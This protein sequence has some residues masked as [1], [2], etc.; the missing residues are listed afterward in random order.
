M[1]SPIANY[2]ETVEIGEIEVADI[3]H[4]F[5]DKDL[6]GFVDPGNGHSYPPAAGWFYS[7]TNFILAASS[8]KPPLASHMNRR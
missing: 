8:S 7:N 2:S 3:H 4:Q 6:I 5:S 1:T